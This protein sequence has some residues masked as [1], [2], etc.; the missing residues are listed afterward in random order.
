MQQK[1][2]EAISETSCELSQQRLSQLWLEEAVSST[3][4]GL[5]R[6]LLGMCL[7]NFAVNDALGIIGG[8]ARSAVVVPYF[9]MSLLRPA[10]LGYA[11]DLLVCF[12]LKMSA[13]LLAVGLWTATATAV[14][15]SAFFYLV[16]LDATNYSNHHLLYVLAL[17]ILLY[18]NSSAHSLSIEGLLYARYRKLSRSTLPRWHLYALRM[19]FLQPHFWGVV[20][21]FT[22]DGLIR[23]Q[24]V[25]SGIDSL[26][27]GRPSWGG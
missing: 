25:R 1:T 16:T 15:L 4:V 11:L 26:A 10:P 17:I 24:P 7:Y 19:I 14:A 3:P 20:N 23:S 12:A 6:I 2:T 18:T 22:F 8:A 9:G 13:T 21:K 27:G 5:F